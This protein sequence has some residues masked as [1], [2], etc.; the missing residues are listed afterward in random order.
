MSRFVT[1]IGVLGVNGVDDAALKN[2]LRATPA[3]STPEGGL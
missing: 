2:G 3:F 1:A